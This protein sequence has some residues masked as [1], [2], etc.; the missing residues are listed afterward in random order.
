MLVW[1]FYQVALIMR[2]KALKQFL[3]GLGP[4][5]GVSDFPFRLWIHL[6][7]TPDVSYTPFLRL[8]DTFPS[9]QGI[10]KFF[11]PEV[12]IP[13]FADLTWW[14]P[15][16]QVMTPSPAFLR[17]L[18]LLVPKFDLPID[19]NCGCPSKT[20]TGNGS[21]SSLLKTVAGFKAFISESQ[22]ALGHLPMSVKMRTGF[23][24]DSFFSDLVASLPKSLRHV[25]IHGRTR[26]Q[27]YLGL[28]NWERIRE[29]KS[30]FG[31]RTLGSGDITTYQSFIDRMHI[32]PDLNGVLIARGAI[33]RPWIFDELEEPNLKIS[34]SQAIAYLELF[35]W[36]TYF[37]DEDKP[38]TF[39]EV[40]PLIKVLRCNRNLRLWREA[41]V[42]LAKRAELDSHLNHF[43][44]R[45][46]LARTKMIW[47]YMRSNWEF[48]Q[49]PEV[50]RSSAFS[51]LIL[52]LNELA[53]TTHE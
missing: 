20:V 8:T 3:K 40:F 15:S 48:A 7:S 53:E 37:W 33:M 30:I 31:G 23:H 14:K 6:I 52:K 13:E 16:L 41:N 17:R 4:M 10:P 21:G 39:V 35:H 43:H 28:A 38:E 29:A 49:S 26:E 32:A 24:D 2:V 12:L 45:R 11:W 36:L 47:S 44:P 9:H 25:T 18:S 46:A 27:K 22:D 34:F 19:I 50:M 51:E 1:A 42:Q 5:E